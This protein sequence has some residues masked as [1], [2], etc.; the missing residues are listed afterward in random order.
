MKRSTWKEYV[1]G[2]VD[3]NPE[4]VSTTIIL[5]TVAK[6]GRGREMRERDGGLVQCTL[7]NLPNQ[8]GGDYQLLITTLHLETYFGRLT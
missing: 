7:R 3:L 2:S 4:F 6:M 1:D 8:P 5:Q